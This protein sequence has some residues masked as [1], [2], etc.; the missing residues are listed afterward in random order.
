MK[1]G[2]LART[3]GKKGGLPQPICSAARGGAVNQ[4]AQDRR[5]K[6]HEAERARG[7]SSAAGIPERRELCWF[8]LDD[9]NPGRVG[10]THQPIAELTVGLK[11]VSSG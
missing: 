7:S 3:L 9:G 2:P 6:N 8:E 4:G 1:N 11:T 5:Q 10:S